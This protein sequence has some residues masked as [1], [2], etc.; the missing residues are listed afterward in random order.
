[1][2]EKRQIAPRDALRLLAPGPV[3][4]VST[5][6]RDQPNVMTAAWLLPLSL[7]PVRVGVAVHPTRLTHEFISKSE[8][9][10]IN[11]PNVDL[12]TAVHTC[13]LRS[14]RDGDKFAATGL[15]PA[16]AT[17]V[18]APLIAECVAHIECG[19]VERLTLGDHD[20]FVGSVLAV[21]ALDEAFGGFWDVTTDAGR[22]LHHL[23]ADRYAGLGRP[24]RASLPEE[25]E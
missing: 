24:Y 23:G 5:M 4:L 9:F 16:E 10:A 17:E 6:Y 1:M 25:T 11:I 15:T 19:V 13:G 8:W 18:E 14:G 2:A 12:I 7:D 20:L 22:L 21:S 3:A